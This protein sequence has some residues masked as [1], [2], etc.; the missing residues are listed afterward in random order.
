METETV[1]GWRMSPSELADTRRKV[2]Q[3]Q[4]RAA[5]R[6]FTGGLQLIAEPETWTQ[7]VSSG[8]PVQRS[9][10]RVRLTGEPACYNGWRLLAA[11]D[12]L[13]DQQGEESFI[14]RCA[15]GVDDTV[16][17]RST[18]RAGE[19]QHCHT[20]RANRIH[21]YLVQHAETGELRQVGAT[22]LKDFLG[23]SV[24]PTFYSEEDL[25]ETIGG[26]VGRGT[27]AWPVDEVLTIAEAIVT[28]NGR[29]VPTGFFGGG[30]CPT[31]HLV[32]QVLAGDRRK[33]CRELRE[34]IEP[35]LADARA[36]VVDDM[37]PALLEHLTEP[38]GYEANLRTVLQ[39][40]YL[41]P[42]QIGLAASAA[43]AYRR[44]L[45][46]QDRA[47]Q[48]Q[49]E[50]AETPSAWIGDI[51]DKITVTGVLT[52]AMTIDGYAYRTTQRLLVLRTEHGVIKMI[53]AAS[54]AYDA[55]QGDTIT[56]EGTVKAHDTYRDLKQTVLKRP[57]R[58]DPAAEAS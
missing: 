39:A 14:V 1:P 33:G 13:P 27:P 58:R 53:T 5:K 34:A 17:D 23:W 51:G 42:K 43:G 6:G 9:G 49:K 25:S 22:C 24:W 29:F 30:V 15:P 16:V 19:C 2:E 18:L 4:T 55:D 21:L 12:S 38:H 54:W 47:A 31:R 45:G 35:L 57:R 37:I 36:R 50:R 52:T 40:S 46:E 20:T 3:T 28:L 26:F 32:E 41:E 10:F 8:N 44:L 48:R 56:V 11:V 7:T